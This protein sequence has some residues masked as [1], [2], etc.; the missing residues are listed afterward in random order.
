MAEEQAEDSVEV[1]VSANDN[2]F[3]RAFDRMTKR[4]YSFSLAADKTFAN[5]NEKLVS[6]LPKVIEKLDEWA[7]K[8]NEEIG[9][10]IGQGLGSLA[11]SALGLILGPVGVS[12]GK[13][14][15]GAIGKALAGPI[16][17]AFEGLLPVFREAMDSAEEML[18]DFGLEFVDQITST[19]ETLDRM[20]KAL[21]AINMHSIADSGQDAI[22]ELKAAGEDWALETLARIEYVAN[23]FLEKF[24]APLA[25]M[26]EGLQ[27]IL[28]KLGL[29]QKGTR[30][31]GEE[32]TKAD[33]IGERMITSLVEML[34]NLYDWFRSMGDGIHDIL[35]PI[36]MM[37][38][39]MLRGYGLIARQMGSWETQRDLV[40]R[41]D[42]LE[43]S[44]N[45]GI[46]DRVSREGRKPGQT[47]DEWTKWL[48]DRLG[49]ARE[50]LAARQGE[51]VGP[52]KGA[53]A[54]KDAEGIAVRTSAYGTA[55]TAA[56]LARA[57]QAAINQPAKKDPAEEAN[58]K[59]DKQ[60]R[61]LEDQLRVQKDT[62]AAVRQQGQ[63]ILVVG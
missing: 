31:W 51:R 38:V 37:I 62:L 55:E 57:R 32:I 42:R 50:L 7:E 11:G 8:T 25:V 22:D 6:S 2:L 56:I 27:A 46:K 17:V 28:E 30:S 49:K 10:Q 19:T 26:A 43:K 54:G 53:E 5:F 36:A 12:I 20:R 44:V 47:A 63:E 15:G 1:E 33:N 16:G 14:L 21:A 59:L 9:E 34:A 48:R 35:D 29:V 4:L 58:K 23:Q 18:Q 3:V 13:T 52:E 61:L 40:A 60:A 45:D 24:R 39:E 41:S